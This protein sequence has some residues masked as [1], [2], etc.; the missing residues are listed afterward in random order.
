EPESSNH[1]QRDC[2]QSKNLWQHIL[3]TNA[4]CDFFT[5]N[6]SRWIKDN[7][8]SH[9]RS[10]FHFLNRSIVFN[11]M[12]WLIWFSRNKSKA[13]KQC[14]ISQFGTSRIKPSTF[15]GWK[16]SQDGFLMLNTD[17]TSAGNLDSAGSGGMFRDAAG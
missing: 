5:P 1:V 15:I 13:V 6:S 2:M 3:L 17:G 12:C 11:I 16:P 4:T 9:E 8:K 14:L 10:K 7:C